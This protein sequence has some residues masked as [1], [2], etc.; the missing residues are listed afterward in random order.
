[1]STVTNPSL[2]TGK[3]NHAPSILKPST[4]QVTV[5][6]TVQPGTSKPSAMTEI[7]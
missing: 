6:L 4:W 7:M 1:M 2:S 3:L 5:G